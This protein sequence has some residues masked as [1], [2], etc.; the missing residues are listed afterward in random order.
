MKSFSSSELSPK[1]HKISA[2]YLDKVRINWEWWN[3]QISTFSSA[4]ATFVMPWLSQWVGVRILMQH[5]SKALWLRRSLFNFDILFSITSLPKVWTL[6]AVD[7]AVEIA[8][9]AL[10]FNQGECCCAGSRTLVHEDIYDAFVK[11]ST[12]RAGKRMVGCPFD[13]ATTQGPQVNECFIKLVSFILCVETRQYKLDLISKI[14]S[15]L[16]NG[17]DHPLMRTNTALL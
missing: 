17:P 9:N 14:Y 12:A 1:Y 16:I 3:C 15:S 11:K 7:E 13:A 4:K 5:D 8:H 6:S 2:R 10:F